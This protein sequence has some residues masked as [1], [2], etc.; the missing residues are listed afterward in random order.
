VCHNKKWRLK[1]RYGTNASRYVF[2]YIGDFHL[3][4]AIVNRE[5]KFGFLDRNCKI[6]IPIIYDNVS[7]FDSNGMAKVS[8][9]GREFFIDREGSKVILDNLS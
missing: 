3:S 2:D 5:N 7:I 6:V 9:D 4:R 1:T 8:L